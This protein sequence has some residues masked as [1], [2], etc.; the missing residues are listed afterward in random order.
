MLALRDNCLSNNEDTWFTFVVEL[1]YILK[2]GA[3][4]NCISLSSPNSTLPAKVVS[5]R[6]IVCAKVPVPYKYT[7]PLSC[8]CKNTLS[9]VPTF[10]DNL[11][12]P[13]DPLFAI[14]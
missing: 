1:W 12:L 6:V 14:W 13:L 8:A 7:L 4:P 5:A 11:K 2:S 9:V 3:P 10:L